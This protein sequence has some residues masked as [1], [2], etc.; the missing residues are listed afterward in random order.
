MNPWLISLKSLNKKFNA[1]L[2]GFAVRDFLIL[3]S[4][5]F[6]SSDPQRKA[7]VLFN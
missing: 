2:F 4:S 6:S 3:S 1:N 7:R 5:G